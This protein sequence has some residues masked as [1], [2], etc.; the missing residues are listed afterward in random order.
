MRC[1][2]CRELVS[3]RLD[4][5]AGDTGDVPEGAVD[6][7]LAGCPDCRAFADRA[8]MVTRL[9]RT[10]PAET[11][12]DLTDAVVTASRSLRP[13][14]RRR[15][16][17]TA[18]RSGLALVGAGQLAL[19]VAAVAGAS[20]TDHDAMHVGGASV[21]H[22]VHETSAWNLAIGIGF[23][24]VAWAG[25]RLVAGLLPVTGAFVGVLAVLSA[26]DLVAGRVE[27]DRLATHALVLVGFL[28]LLLHRRV[29]GG[30]G[31][32]AARRDRRP[33]FPSEAPDAALPWSG[34][35]TGPGAVAQDDRRAA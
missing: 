33:A 3:A 5:E 21:T 19:A 31:P 12:P 7:H 14:V 17:G 1:D 34:P 35:A 4:G 23:L 28:L 13:V 6:A 8:A 26:L 2:R 24:A 11:G 22:A 9:A 30:D 25:G 10:G 27:P 18:V 16:A 32:R 15:R 20:G 29:L